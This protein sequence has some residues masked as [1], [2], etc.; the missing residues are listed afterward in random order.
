MHYHLH[1][2]LVLFIEV[3]KGQSCVGNFLNGDNCVKKHH[4]Y[5]IFV[6]CKL[7]VLRVGGN[8]RNGFTDSLI[9]EQQ[10]L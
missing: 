4:H 10:C 2:I 1:V 3:N 8:F 6:T 9:F 7:A 5:L